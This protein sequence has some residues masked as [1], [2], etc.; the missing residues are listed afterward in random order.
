MLLASIEPDVAWDWPSLCRLCVVT[1]FALILRYS[2]TLQTSH[3]WIPSGFVL[4]LLSG[5][6][7]LWG[8][9]CL[10]GVWERVCVLVCVS[11]L[12]LY[13]ASVFMYPPLDFSPFCG[14]GHWVTLLSR[15]LGGW[16]TANMNPPVLYSLALS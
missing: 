11:D 8:V 12:S 6:A 10:R 16:H 15:D 4:G 2:P 9:L 1:A 13:L 14:P 5:C 3:D 7:R